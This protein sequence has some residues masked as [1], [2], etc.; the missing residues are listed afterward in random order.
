MTETLTRPPPDT[1]AI[2][3]SGPSHP[4]MMTVSDVCEMTR[5]SRATVTRMIKERA[6]Q[7]IKIRTRRLV[8]RAS[9]LS[10]LDKQ[11]DEK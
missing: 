2:V 8:F 7:S 11:R 4:P 5:L 1:I 3:V 6:F 9:V 10:Y